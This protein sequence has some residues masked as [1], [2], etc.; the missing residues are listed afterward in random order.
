MS[1]IKVKVKIEK[2]LDGHY[3]AFAENV[4]GITGEG[5]TIWKVKKSVASCLEIQ[6]ELGNLPS[7]K[8][9]LVFIED[10]K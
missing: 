2:S 4:E 10:L 6:L 9:E 1:K 8:Y 5:S 7:G 3:W